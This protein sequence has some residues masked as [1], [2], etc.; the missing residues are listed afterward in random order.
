VKRNRIFLSV[1]IVLLVSVFFLFTNIGKKRAVSYA[2]ETLAF[3]KEKCRDFDGLM[4]SVE[5]DQS[6]E[7]VRTYVE[8]LLTDS[9]L[10]MK[11]VILICN[12]ERVLCSN[13]GD[14]RGRELD[15]APFISEIKEGAQP[16]N[17]CPCAIMALLIMEV[18]I[19]R[20][21]MTCMY[22]SF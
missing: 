10:E 13:Y 18:W 3:L 11:G 22:L 2:G 9:Q 21:I 8:G 17:F 7:A 6:K 19:M 20:A 4:G 16:G 1:G 15:K 14:Y 5:G 12:K